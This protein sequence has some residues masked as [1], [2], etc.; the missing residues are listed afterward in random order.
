MFVVKRKINSFEEILFIRLRRLK[1]VVCVEQLS[2]IFSVI[3]WFVLYGEVGN[4]LFYGILN[5]KRI[6]IIFIALPTVL[7]IL[8]VQG[9]IE[10]KLFLLKSELS[11]FYFFFRGVS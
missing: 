5:R 6:Y 3:L 9:N 2:P 7:A 4:N 1:R 8:N 11:G 10:I